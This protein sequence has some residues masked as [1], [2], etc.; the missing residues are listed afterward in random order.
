MKAI[1]K[2]DVSVVSK[3]PKPSSH[4]KEVPQGKKP[5][6]KSILRRKQSSKHIFESQTKVS[7]SKTGQ[8]KTKTK[9]SLAKDKSHSHPLPPT[10]VV[11]EMHKEAQQAAG[12]PTY[13]EA[14]SKEGAHPQLSSGSN[15]SVRVDKT[16][17]TGDGLKTTHT[18]SDESEEQ[19]VDKED[20]HDTSHDMPKDTSVPPLPS[21]KLAQI[22]NLMAQALISKRQPAYY[23]SGT[24]SRALSFTSSSFFSLETAQD[25]GFP[26]KSI[27]QGQATASPAEGEKNTNDVETNL[28]DELVNLLGTNVMTQYYNKKL[29]FDKYYDK[30]LKRKKIPKI[31][32]CEVLTKKGPITLKIYREDGSEEVISNLKVSD[33]HLAEW[34]ELIQACPNKS[35]KGWKNIYDLKL[36]RVVS[37]LEGLQDGKKI[38]LC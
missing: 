5:G 21:L 16:K 7:K 15:L 23:S 25:F 24:S 22:Q 17:S 10:L 32:N 19:E 1:Y 18:D 30:M 12:G 20:T 9:S 8:S 2:L 14:T 35:E 34:R 26:S 36:K 29:L 6:A 11:D 33:L 13:L 37:L 38:D 3:A 28:K 4:T 27:K 31:T